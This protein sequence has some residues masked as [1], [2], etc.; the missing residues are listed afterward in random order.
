MKIK[1]IRLSWTLLNLWDRGDIDRAVQAYFH[2]GGSITPQMKEGKELHEKIAKY[3]DAHKAFPEWFFNYDLKSPETEKEV[4]VSY[5]KYFN[6]KGFFDCYDSATKTLFEFKTGKT[7][8][9]TWARSGQVP[10]YFLLGELAGLEIERAILIRYNQYIKETDFC[11][12]HNSKK[13]RD[14]ARNLIDSVGIEIH[15]FF[16]DNNLL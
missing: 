11:I 16:L 6:L 7:D 15:S 9:L 5:N 14:G 1:K 8:S 12:I 4:I 10:L 3:I 13:L 2:I